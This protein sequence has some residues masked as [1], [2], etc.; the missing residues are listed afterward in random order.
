[1]I[2][3]NQR[4]KEMNMT[5]SEGGKQ[6]SRPIIDDLAYD[7]DLDKQ[8][9]SGLVKDQNLGN[10]MDG[11]SDMDGSPNKTSAY[12]T[13]TK[14]ARANPDVRF[15]I[16]TDP[17]DPN[18]PTT[19]VTVDIDLLARNRD[20]GGGVEFAAGVEGLGHKSVVRY[21]KINSISR[22]QAG[23]EGVVGAIYRHVKNF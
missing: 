9:L 21:Y 10:E 6:V 18:S 13:L 7:G 12:P 5:T 4:I 17:D 20:G 22:G 15:F 16:P 19:E 23:S 11:D 3:G 2:A 1:M 14:D 8:E